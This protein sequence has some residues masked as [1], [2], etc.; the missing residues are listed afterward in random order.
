MYMYVREL[1]M[2]YSTSGKCLTNT[3][4]STNYFIIANDVKICLKLTLSQSIYVSR[5]IT[6]SMLTFL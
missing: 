2:L 5:P 4:F 3:F 6:C 1:S